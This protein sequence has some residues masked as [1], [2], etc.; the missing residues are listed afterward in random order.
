MDVETERLIERLQAVLPQKNCVHAGAVA[1]TGCPAIDA[2]LP[3]AGVA[4]GTLGDGV[5]SA[6]GRGASLCAFRMARELQDEGSVVVVDRREAFY[7]PAAVALRNHLNNMIV[8]HPANEQDE[9]WSIDQALRCEHVGAVIAWPQQISALVFRRWQLAAERGGTLGLL[10]RP[11]LAL[12]QPSW[13]GL[14]MSVT[15][16]PHSAPVAPGDRTLRPWRLEVELLR[17]RGLALGRQENI[18]VEIDPVTG[19]I[20]EMRPRHLAAEFPAAPRA[21]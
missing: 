11:A 8:V 17:C 18:I 13:A 3:E 10:V 7:P 4:R 9:Q 6:S 5:A 2:R 16:R 19:D 14:R 21:G 1:S 15:P 20:H 12:G